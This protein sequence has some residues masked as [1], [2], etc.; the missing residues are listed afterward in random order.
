[1]SKLRDTF[2]KPKLSISII[3]Q[4]HFQDLDFIYIF[5]LKIYLKYFK[6]ILVYPSTSKFHDT[7]QGSTNGEFIAQ[8]YGYTYIIAC[9]IGS[10]THAY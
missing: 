3:D 6:W 7:T 4:T 1:M 5:K 10:T 8:T 2:Y 9:K